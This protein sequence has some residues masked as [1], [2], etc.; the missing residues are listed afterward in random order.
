MPVTPV[1]IATWKFGVEASEVGWRI[2]SAGGNALDAVEQGANAVEENPTVS[3]VGY[4]GL[5]NAEGVVELDAAIMDGRNH[6]AGAVAAITG[7]RKPISV[8]RRVMEKT[9][10]VMLA[11][12]NARRFALKEG[13]PDAELLTEESR[14]KWSEWKLTHTAPDVAHFEEPREQAWSEERKDLSHD[15]V[16]VCALD[17]EGNLAAGCTTSGLAWKTPGRVGDSPIVGSGL[18]VDNRFGAAAATGNGDEMMKVCLSYRVVMLMELGVGPQ[19]ACE[20]AIRYLLKLRPGSQ[21]RGAAC[22]GLSKDGRVGAAATRDGF[23]SPDRLWHYS[24]TENGAVILK[25]GIYVDA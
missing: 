8:A 15:T 22:I 24:Y 9:P 6:S 1:Y 4:G 21:S 16:G 2:L 23:H 17:A 20:E 19:E 12:L 10:H 3:S 5:P 25:E 11:G 13:F 14:R 7:I 18:Y